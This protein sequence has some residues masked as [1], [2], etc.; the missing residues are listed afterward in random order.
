MFGGH[1][2]YCDGTMFALI[3]DD[4]LYFK[5]DDSNRPRYAAL[6]LQPFK[7]FADRPTVMSYYPVPFE[8]LEDPDEVFI[9][10][11]E[12]FQVA[13]RAAAAKAAKKPRRRVNPTSA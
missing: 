2:I 3:A 13:R 8:V 7:P 1:G 9:W 6:G 10:A 11:T 4:M 12:A 5:V